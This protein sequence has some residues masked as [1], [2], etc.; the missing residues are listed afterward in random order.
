LLIYNESKLDLAIKYFWLK[1]CSINILPIFALITNPLKKPTMK[2]QLKKVEINS[3]ISEIKQFCNLHLYTDVEPFEVIQI[4][5]TK[6]VVIRPLHA[7]RISEM[8]F[9]SGGFAGHCVNNYGQKWSYESLPDAN[10]ITI[11]LTKKGWGQGMHK[12]NHNPIKFYDFNF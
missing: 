5:N 10:T 1:I 2:T 11:T 7:T 3:E 9:V 8:E 12:M 4:I 6:K